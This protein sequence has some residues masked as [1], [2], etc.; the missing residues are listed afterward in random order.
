MK[1]KKKKHLF[2]SKD[3]STATLFVNKYVSDFNNNKITVAQLMNKIICLFDRFP[4]QEVM[5][6]LPKP[7]IKALY[8]YGKAYKAVEDHP[9]MELGIFGAEVEA[10]NY[11]ID[12]H[13]KDIYRQWLMY[14]YFE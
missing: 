14:D 1:K 4:V 8:S 9:C 6:L 10:Y 7:I 13:F 5:E 3:P 12:Q 11:T 2:V